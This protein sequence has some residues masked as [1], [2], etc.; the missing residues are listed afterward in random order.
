MI[1]IG[2]YINKKVNEFIRRER[3]SIANKEYYRLHGNKRRVPMKKG[4][5]IIG[6]IY[7]NKR[8]RN[9][10]KFYGERG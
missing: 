3:I 2:R 4:G 8:P 10:C 6:Y 7:L 9:G 1:G 5:Q